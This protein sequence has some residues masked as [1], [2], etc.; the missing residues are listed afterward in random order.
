MS[1]KLLIQ[2][3][4]VRS[5]QRSGDYHNNEHIYIYNANTWLQVSHTGQHLCV[6]VAD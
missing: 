4:T 6:C 2:V 5:F 3:L 1:I